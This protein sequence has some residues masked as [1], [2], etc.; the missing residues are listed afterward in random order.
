MND[1]ACPIYD[2][3]IT[4]MMAGH[5]FL[6]EEFG[7]SPTIGWHVDPFGHSLANQ[8][9]FS[10]MGIEAMIFSRIDYQD[11][12]KRMKTKELEWVWESF[13]EDRGSNSTI[14]A[15]TMYYHYFPP[16]GFCWEPNNC[17]YYDEP[18]IADKSLKTYNIES[19]AKELYE[20]VLHMK[21]HYRSNQLLIPFGGDFF[22][23]NA[24]K[25]YKNIDNLI[26]GFNRIYTD[27]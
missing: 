3:I 8:Y 27:V 25:W 7:V 21:E 5:Q 23:K 22:Y 24:L 26:E 9:L 12:E 16:P 18:V 19:R 2:D 6:H 1:E 14:F 15:H 10:E 20:W 4:N 11:K 13:S 17:G